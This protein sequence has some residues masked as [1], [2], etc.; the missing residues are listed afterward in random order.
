MTEVLLSKSLEVSGQTEVRPRGSLVVSGPRELLAKRG[1]A[2]AFNPD[3]SPA[4]DT[5][6]WPNRRLDRISVPDRLPN[7]PIVEVN[8]E[9]VV[10]GGC[11]QPHYGHFLTESVS[12]LWPLLP[13]G[14]LEGMPVVCMRPSQK[15]HERE[16]DEAFG[17]RPIALPEHGVVRF[18]KMFVPEPAWMLPRAWIAPEIRDIHLHARQNLDVPKVSPQG[19]LWLSRSELHR[20]Q[21]AYDE[22]LLEWMLADHVTLVHPQEKGLAE[23]VAL[24]EASDAVAGLVG[25]AFHTLLTVLEPPDSFLLCK[26]VVP[27]AFVT[28]SDLLNTNSIFIQALADAEMHRRRRPLSLGGKRVLIPEA[29]RAL[30]A[31]LLSQ[32]REDPRVAPFAHPESLL[33]RAARYAGKTEMETAVAKVLLDPYSAQA[34]IRLA[35]LFGARELDRCALEQYAIVA[36]MSD[37]SHVCA[38]LGMARIL[39]RS[40]Q[41]D[42]ASAVAKRVLEVDPDCQAAMSLDIER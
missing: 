9:E 22:A 6:V 23:Q 31:S 41:L 38:M 19:V 12:R 26:S 28:Q 37:D 10:W 27:S 11:V 24:I 1:V 33:P 3:R 18:T 35:E 2:A 39:A 16:W 34:R 36:E 5:R 15:R 7:E 4:H 29:L 8:D 17:V 30:S 14:E 42:D 32:L 25:S 21:R 20:K 40:G 13:G